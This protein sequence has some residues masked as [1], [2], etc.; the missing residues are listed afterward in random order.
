MKEEEEEEEKEKE[1]KEWMV[2]VEAKDRSPRPLLSHRPLLQ[3]LFLQPSPLRWCLSTIRI[4]HRHCI[5]SS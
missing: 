5:H 4:V 2:V 3:R 1:Q